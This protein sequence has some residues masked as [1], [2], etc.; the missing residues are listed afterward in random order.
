MDLRS[1]IISAGGAACRFT[2]VSYDADPEKTADIETVGVGDD[3]PD[4]PLILT[5]DFHVMVPLESTYRA[6]RDA[7]PE[8]YRDAVSR[9]V[10][11]E[12]V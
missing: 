7:S 2:R 10:L 5:P 12:P 11:P 9:G 3:L 4:M 8:G 6:T 1:G